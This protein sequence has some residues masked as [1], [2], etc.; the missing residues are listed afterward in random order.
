MWKT[1]PGTEDKALVLEVVYKKYY[2]M[3]P[4][5]GSWQYPTSRSFWSSTEN[6]S[7]ENE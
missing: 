7:Y 6:S 5:A 3:K 2:F 4:E 1:D